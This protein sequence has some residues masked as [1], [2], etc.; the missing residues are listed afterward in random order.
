LG[1]REGI[2]AKHI[3]LFSEIR[4]KIIHQKIKQM[5]KDKYQLKTDR[6]AMI[7]YL[8]ARIRYLSFEDT[9][10]LCRKCAFSQDINGKNLCP[11]CRKNYKKN[12]V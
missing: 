5:V 11:V 3:M 8:D 12:T 1:A 2:I 9:I 6:K 10:T 4:D 7:D